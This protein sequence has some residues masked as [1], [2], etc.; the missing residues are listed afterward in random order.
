MARVRSRLITWNA[1]QEQELLHKLTVYNETITQEAWR[2]G[3]ELNLGRPSWEGLPRLYSQDDI[4]AMIAAEG[5][6]E[7]AFRR[8]IGY[9]KDQSMLTRVTR[10]GALATTDDGRSTVYEKKERQYL[11]RRRKKQIE[12]KRKADGYY[13]MTKGEQA[14][15]RQ[16]TDERT[17]TGKGLSADLEMFYRLA[18]REYGQRYLDVLITNQPN[19]PHLS[20]IER[21]V[22]RFM[23]D[24]PELLRDI[25]ESNADE[26]EIYYLYWDSPDKTPMEDYSENGA[27]MAGRMRKVYNFWQEQE[28]IAISEGYF[29]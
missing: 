11:E 4:K 17:K 14:A 21:I 9:G 10:P 1:H 25:F 5:N 23:E 6:T 29:E 3:E 8:L 22:R 7:A 27:K 12:D 18:D 26:L 28:Q 20:E 15:Y 24:A 19:N 2:R 16:H 13:D